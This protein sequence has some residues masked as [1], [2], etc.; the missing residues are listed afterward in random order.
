L[1]SGQ[2]YAQDFIARIAVENCRLKNVQTSKNDLYEKETGDCFPI[3]MFG[4]QKSSQ[5][6]Y[7][8]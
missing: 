6:G 2:E 4:C 3:K 7:V 8:C 5:Q 1:K